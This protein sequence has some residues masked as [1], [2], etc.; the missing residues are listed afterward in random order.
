M[1]K[2]SFLVGLMLTTVAL[3]ATAGEVRSLRVWAGPDSTRAVLDLNQQVKY[4]LFTLDNPSRVVIDIDSVD[5]E[6]A[7][8]LDEEHSGVIR[9][10]RHGV[11]E[12]E[13]LRVVLDLEADVRPQSFLL[14]PAG[15]YGHRLVVDLYPRDAQSPDERVREAVQPAM[16]GER[17]MIV[18]IDAGH[19]GED[20]GAIGPGGTYEKTV[21]MALARELKQQVDDEPGMRAVLIRTGDY[22][23]PLEERYAR[24]RE[25]RA[26]L[27]VSLHADAFRDFR[28]RGSSVYVLS[29][30]GAS[31]EAARMLAK[32]E[33]RSDLVGGVKL[34]RGDD[35][36]S[37]V[38]LDLSQNVAMEYSTEAAESILGQL[39][40]VGK[41]HREQVE[42]ANFVVLRS[43]DVPSVLLEVGFISNPHDEANLK[44]G[45]HRRQVGEAIVDGVRRHFFDTAPQGTWIAANR[46]GDRHI[47][48]RGDTL[49]VIAS[50]YRT[51]VS[52]I[53]QANNI[54]GD[55]IHPGAVLVIP[56]GS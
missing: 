40:R 31:S 11:R 33:N 55:V 16:E 42:R 10:V 48:E 38:L 46:D 12:G 41:Q 24:A 28:V 8:N 19:G 50:K 30:R 14:A 26:D 23:V 47:V 36:L 6:Q 53:R 29:R 1:R 5:L 45:T 54:D 4:R 52:R 51:S 9:R 2:L 27:F 37:S 18:A 32:S 56:A 20:P 22:Y 15:E 43:P 21:V 17:D 49:G 7:L 13:H 39:G 34:D 25:A 35:V 44:S 3:S